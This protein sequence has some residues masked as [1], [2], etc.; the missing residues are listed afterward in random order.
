MHPYSTEWYREQNA[1][2]GKNQSSFSLPRVAEGLAQCTLDEVRAV[3]KAKHCLSENDAYYVSMI[4]SDLEHPGPPS[5]NLTR[6]YGA[7]VV[8]ADGVWF[9]RKKKNQNVSVFGQ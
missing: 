8:K 6:L 4:L 7:R 2:S 5:I 9:C 1:L 3:F